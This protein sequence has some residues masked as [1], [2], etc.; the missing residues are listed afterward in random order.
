MPKITE[1]LRNAGILGDFS[2]LETSAQPD[3]F[4]HNYEDF[5]PQG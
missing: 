1:N 4:P 3:S 2:N 5:A